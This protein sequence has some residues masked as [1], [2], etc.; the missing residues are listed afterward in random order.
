MNNVSISSIFCQVVDIWMEWSGISP[1][2]NRCRSPPTTARVGHSHGSS[3]S[4]EPNVF[5]LF[6][7]RR[8]GNATKRWQKTSAVAPTGIEP[9]SD[10]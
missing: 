5:A 6:D 10:G 2:G 1:N 9:V 3:Y 4:S 8:L 7:S